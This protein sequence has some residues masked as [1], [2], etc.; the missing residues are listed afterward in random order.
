[1]KQTTV[2]AIILGVLVLV[3]LVQAYQLTALKTRLAGGQLSI[4]SGVSRTS[5][6]SSGDSGKKTA[7]LPSNIQE[8]PAMVGGC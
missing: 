8:L 3:S 6:L 2:I 5:P 1:M 7:S 4:S